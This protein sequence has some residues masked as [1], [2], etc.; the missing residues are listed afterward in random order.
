M[1]QEGFD[2]FQAG[3]AD[4]ALKVLHELQGAIDV[5]VADQRMPGLPGAALLQQT[6]V[7]WPRIRR[8]LFTGYATSDLVLNGCAHAVVAKGPDL[9]RLLHAI[10]LQLEAGH[11][12]EKH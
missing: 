11:E 10:T 1:V 4:E 6:A 9:W 12:P 8:I 5:I 7:L 2:V 3:N